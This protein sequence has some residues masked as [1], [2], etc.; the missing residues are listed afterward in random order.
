MT[1]DPT[2]EETLRA[3]AERGTPRGAD[4]V[5]GAARSGSGDLDLTDARER[6]ERAGRPTLAIAAAAVVLVVAAA[7]AALVLRDGSDSSTAASGGPFCAALVQ[8]ALPRDQGL[9]AD[10]AIY[11]EP[12]ASRATIEQ[13]TADLEADATIAVVRY[14]DPD[15]T[16]ERFRELFADEPTLLDHVDPQDL[17]TSF[18]VTV[19]AGA[20]PA[21]VAA[22]W[23]AQERVWD[24]RDRVTDSQRVVDALVWA[25]EDD[26]VT[27]R[28]VLWTDDPSIVEA[29]NGRVDDVRRTATPDVAEAVDVL[30]TALVSGV[31]SPAPDRAGSPAPAA[32]AQ[33]LE[34]AAQRECGL[35]PRTPPVPSAAD[36]ATT[37]TAPSSGD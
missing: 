13:L 24:S 37:T 2:P 31:E 32:A 3:R 5:L 19:A 25:G 22:R 36:G 4:A 30:A 20:D 8:L 26:R 15:E 7:G 11:V 9:A 17:P 16:Y 23:R 27:Q 12:A 1:D 10:V 34:A 18:E 21:Q 33:V 14:V 35:R 28:D 29:W 6:H